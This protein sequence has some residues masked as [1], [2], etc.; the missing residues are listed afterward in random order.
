MT[1]TAAA[2]DGAAPGRA[3]VGR[4]FARRSPAR[5]ALVLLF[6]H[7]AE[8]A[9]AEP[10]AD[11]PAE[12]AARP[13]LEWTATVLGGALWLTETLNIAELAPDECRWCD[14]NALDDSARDLSWANRE[15]ARVTSDVISY[16]IVPVT[17]AGF[18]TA[19]A[20]VDQRASDL[21]V[22]LLIPAEAAVIAGVSGDLI[23]VLTGRER[24]WIRDLSPDQKQQV[25]RPE[26][27]NLSFIS[28]H[29]AT[30]FALAVSSGIVASWRRRRIAPA[31]WTTGL[32]LAVT[33]S[34]LR[35]ASEQHHLTDVLAGI[36]A[37]VAIGLAVPFVHRARDAPSRA[38]V[39]VAPLPDGALLVVS[40][41]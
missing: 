32:T 27:N 3:G 26:Q 11:G 1:A 13:G 7:T 28:G 41:R 25:A 35:I 33:T 39:Y 10:E 6:V 37:G 21:T 12:L 23:R 15:A 8:I 14:S 40:L 36:G 38:A 31:V 4:R 29:S 18:L 20:L 19:G 2:T 16:G 34:Y 30:A 24:P 9:R 5:L 17:A 22:D